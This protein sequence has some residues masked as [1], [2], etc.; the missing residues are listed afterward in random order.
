MAKTTIGGAPTA[1]AAILIA[2]MASRGAAACQSH[3]FQNAKL[4]KIF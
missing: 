3:V 4:N 2:T 1:L